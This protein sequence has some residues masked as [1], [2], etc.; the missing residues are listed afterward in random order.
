MKTFYVNQNETQEQTDI[1]PAMILA[2]KEII[3]GIEVL[4]CKKQA[5]PS[6]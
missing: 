6:H 3:H 5:L 1:E 2:L 4:A